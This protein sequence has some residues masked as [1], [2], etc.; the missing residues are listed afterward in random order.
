MG[1]TGRFV[2]CSARS[3]SLQP[4][5]RGESPT[6]R[7]C[8][9]VFSVFCALL[10]PVGDVVFAVRDVRY[11]FSHPSPSLLPFSTPDIHTVDWYD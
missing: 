3:A 5:R 1:E 11:P 2:S 8:D 9:R 4:T 10:F 7:R 6:V